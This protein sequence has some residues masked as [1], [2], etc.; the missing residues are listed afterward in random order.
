[1][2]EVKEILLSVAESGHQVILLTHDKRLRE[3][4]LLVMELGS[5]TF[6]RSQS[7]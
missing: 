1:M 2:E 7:N 3:W 4:G 6:V 5:L